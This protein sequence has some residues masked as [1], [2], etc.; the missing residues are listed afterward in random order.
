MG[1][2]P[3]EDVWASFLEAW[4]RVK[5]AADNGPFE[6]LWAESAT[7]KQPRAA[8]AYEDPRLRRLVTFC[9]LLQRHA[10]GFPF[11]LDCRRIGLLLGVHRNR[12]WRWLALVLVADGVL[13]LVAHG[14]WTQA[15][16]NE[17]RFV[18]PN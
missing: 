5:Y 9:W 1:K 10:G 17:Y 12:V 16:A 4:P 18:A 13:E 7:A 2:V 15:K 8:R 3:F 11:P 14:D 6:R